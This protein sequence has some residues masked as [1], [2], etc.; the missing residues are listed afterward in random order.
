[1]KSQRKLTKFLEMS[2]SQAAI[3][4]SVIDWRTVNADSDA[5]RSGREMCFWR[6]SRAPL[7]RSWIQTSSSIAARDSKRDNTLSVSSRT[8]DLMNPPMNPKK[9]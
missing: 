3:D 2:Q 4:D 8:V 1:M 9:L 5:A 7:A 6:Y